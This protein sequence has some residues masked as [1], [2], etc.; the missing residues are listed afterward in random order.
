MPNNP[1]DMAATVRKHCRVLDDDSS[2]RRPHKF[3]WLGPT[4]AINSLKRK[5]RNVCFLHVAF[6]STLLP[7]T[8][9]WH[10]HSWDGNAAVME[11]NGTTGMWINNNCRRKITQHT[12]QSHYW[13]YSGRTQQNHSRLLSSQHSTK[14]M[15]PVDFEKRFLAAEAPL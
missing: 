13:H 7:S 2:S 1:N 14:N 8:Q 6:A 3:V 9:K 4:C 5:K 12:T 11:Q 15:L 10:H